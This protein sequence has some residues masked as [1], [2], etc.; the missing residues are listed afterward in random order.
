MPGY[1]HEAELISDEREWSDERN[2]MEN[3]GFVGGELGFEDQTSYSSAHSKRSREMMREYNE[4][5]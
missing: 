3:D 4:N 5:N 1:E 2:I